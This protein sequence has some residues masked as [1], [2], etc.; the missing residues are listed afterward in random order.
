MYMRLLSGVSGAAEVGRLDLILNISSVTR[1]LLLSSYNSISATSLVFAA[2]AWLFILRVRE[3]LEGQAWQTRQGSA[4]LSGH[5]LFI[6]YP[7][8]AH[9]PGEDFIH[10]DV[11]NESVRRDITKGDNIY[12]TASMQGCK[13]FQRCLENGRSY[14]DALQI[15]R[16]V[17][18]PLVVWHD[19]QDS[20]FFIGS[21][22]LP[23]IL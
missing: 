6:A 7:K 11:Y 18:H 1:N 17:T 22:S 4:A 16:K 3:Y 20:P 13:F 15:K 23:R 10:L 19:V 14:L 21:I 8:S 5:V 2:L 12:I 9:L